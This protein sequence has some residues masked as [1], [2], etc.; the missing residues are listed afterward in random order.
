MLMFKINL[1]PHIRKAILL[2]F[3]FGVMINT[4]F[5]H[6]SIIIFFCAEGVRMLYYFLYIESLFSFYFFFFFFTI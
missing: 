6:F 4:T 2:E 5:L 1:K 3:G